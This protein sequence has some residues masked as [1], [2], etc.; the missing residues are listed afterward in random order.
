MM[1]SLTYRF[2]SQAR[3]QEMLDLQ[4]LGNILIEGEDRFDKLTWML[5][6]RILGSPIQQGEVHF[7]SRTQRHLENELETLEKL[8][9]SGVHVVVWGTRTEVAFI[10]NRFD[11]VVLEENLPVAEESFFI[12][13]FNGCGR[14][15]VAWNTGAGGD[16]T[17]VKTSGVFATDPEATATLMM[18]IHSIL[19]V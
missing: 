6:K 3:I 2:A 19:E 11:T 12:A 5:V 18:R 4:D 17:N 16:N 14:T 13:T 8:A 10:Q 1:T 9:A 7:H 15:L